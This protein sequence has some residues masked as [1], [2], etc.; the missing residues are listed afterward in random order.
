[1]SDPENEA[2][3]EKIIEA[4]GEPRNYGP[5]PEEKE[6]QERKRAAEEQQRLMQEAAERARRQAEEEIRMAALLKEWVIHTLLR[7]KRPSA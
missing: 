2:V 1:M 7:L 6:E 4:V 3:M 5:T